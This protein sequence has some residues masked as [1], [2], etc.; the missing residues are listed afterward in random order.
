MAST[1]F[2]TRTMN[3]DRQYPLVAV[4]R[5][6]FESVPVGESTPVLS[7]PGNAIVTGGALVVQTAW[8][9]AGTAVVDLGDS[10]DPDE[11]LDGVD[12]KTLGRTALTLTGFQYATPDTLSALVAEGV[13]ATATAG[14]ALLFVEYIIEGRGGE[15]QK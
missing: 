11:Y 2:A 1:N 3:P 8:D 13:G 10:T 6:S 5:F 4:V 14:E 15:I 12:L 9:S 7:L